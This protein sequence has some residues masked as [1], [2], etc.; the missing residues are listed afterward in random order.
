MS[1]TLF[2]FRAAVLA[3][4]ALLLGGGSA[5]A[6]D[7]K[8]RTTRAPEQ[9][10]FE[11]IAAAVEVPVPGRAA[12][13]KAEQGQAAAEKIVQTPACVRQVKVIYAG[14]GERDRAAGCEAVTVR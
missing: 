13:A 7:F 10:R 4:G 2:A 14:Y 9:P 3:G 11:A 12:V 6:L 8:L 5:S 1:A